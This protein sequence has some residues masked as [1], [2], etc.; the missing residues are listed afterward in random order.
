MISSMTGYGSASRQ[1]SLGAGVVAD[2]QVEC[3]AVNSR[4]L[5]LGFRLPDECRGA[6]PA[7]RELVS[8]SLSRGKVEFRAAWRINSSNNNN[9][10]AAT[11]NPHSLGTLNQDRLDALYTL[12]EKAQLSF[13]NAPELRMGEILR[14]P[15]IV[16]EPRG[17]EEGWVAATIEAGKAALAVLLESRHAEG[18]ALVGVLNHITTQMREIVKTIEP[19]VPQYVAQYQEKLT[20]RLSEALAAQEQ[21]KAGAELMER[22]RQ[23]VVLYAVRIDVAEE[24]ARLKTHLQA[25]D[26]ALAG[27][28]PVGKRLDFL[29]QELNR[30]A[31]TL[32]SKSVSEECTQAALELKLFIEQMREQVQNLE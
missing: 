29:M 23:E 21:A 19:K 25:V 27:K 13:P 20:E 18:K 24:F 14:W 17:E 31:N 32:S 3:R 9:S 16:S 30:E 11:A 10:G 1:V 15:G 26:T 22:I 6:E 12:Q 4:F 2:L 28:G 5:D 7:L 8:Q